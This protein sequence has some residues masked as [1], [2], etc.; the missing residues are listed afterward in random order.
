MTPVAS[1]HAE[2]RRLDEACLTRVRVGGWGWAQRLA[3]GLEDKLV[4][5]HAARRGAWL[6]A[7]AEVQVRVRVR[8]RLSPGLGLGLPRRLRRAPRRMP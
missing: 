3:A 8:V 5:G 1:P 6:G 2:T 4:L 7:R